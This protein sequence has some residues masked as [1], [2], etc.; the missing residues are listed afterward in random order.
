MREERERER[1]QRGGDDKPFSKATP[2]TFFLE[3]HVKM[4]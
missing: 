1:E 4:M 2:K 3:L